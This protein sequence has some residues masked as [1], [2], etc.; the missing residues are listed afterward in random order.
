MEAEAVDEERRPEFDDVFL[1]D[2]GCRY[3]GGQW[4]RRPL[5]VVKETPLTIFVNRQELVTLLCT[6]NKLTQLVVGFLHLEGLI[7][8]PDDIAYLRVCSE[9]PTADVRLTSESFQLPTRRVLTSGCGGGVGLMIGLKDLAKVDSAAR[10]TPEQVIRLAELMRDSA[11]LYPVSGGVHTSILTDGQRVLAVAED[12][13]RHNTVDKIDGECLLK[14]MSTEGCFIWTTG[15]I[16]SEML[17]KSA[18]MRVP[19]VLSRTSPTHRAVVLAQELGITI[20]G[21]VRGGSFSVYTH[22]HRIEGASTL[23]IHRVSTEQV[24][25]SDDCEA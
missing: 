9:E 23:D 14:G 7:S 17:I 22:R 21:Y 25:G 6:P 20:V 19:V 1:L 13:G 15:R 5:R 12:V 8:A 4:V 10:L 16:S 11:R 3:V 2:S 18:R 24:E